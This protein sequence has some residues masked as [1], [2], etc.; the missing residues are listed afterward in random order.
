MTTVHPDDETPADP[1]RTPS[2]PWSASAPVPTQP[3]H[4]QQLPV[5]PFPQSGHTRPMPHVVVEREIVYVEKP[6]RRK[7]PWVL[8]VLVLLLLCCCGS[9]YGAVQQF[10]GAYPASV[11]V[12]PDVGDRQPTD[13]DGR[14]SS[15]AAGAAACRSGAVG[16]TRSAVCDRVTNALDT[17]QANAVLVTR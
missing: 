7:W 1:N 12:P 10:G 17:C 8:A 13:Y 11:S 6:R 2:D 14:S 16:R 3:G 4:T 9:C 15:C 5:V